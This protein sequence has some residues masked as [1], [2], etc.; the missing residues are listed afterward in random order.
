LIAFAHQRGVAVLNAAPYGS[1]I[2][3]KGPSAYPRYAYS[4]AD[5]DLVKRARQMEAACARHGV[6]LAAAALQFSLRDP[7]ITSTIIG[8]SKPER[9]Q[10]TLELAAVPI[11]DEL[12]PELDALAAPPRE[13]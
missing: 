6:P 3:A 1:G 2:L 7:R 12:W 4:E 9:I 5:A 11:P 13:L 10:Q 8:M